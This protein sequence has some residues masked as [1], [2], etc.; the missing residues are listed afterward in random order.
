MYM[1]LLSFD[2]HDCINSCLLTFVLFSICRI[3][4]H[5]FSELDYLDNAPTRFIPKR[6]ETVCIDL[7]NVAD[8]TNRHLTL[9]TFCIGT[10]WQSLP[11][12]AQN[13]TIAVVS[14]IRAQGT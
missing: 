13:E 10:S 2:I 9:S 11:A 3:F 6:P 5:R 12:S 4:S 1:Q 7:Y 14:V 8:D